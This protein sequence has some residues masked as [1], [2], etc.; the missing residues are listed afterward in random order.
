MEP[1]G[2]LTKDGYMGRVSEL[3]WILFSTEQEYLDYIKED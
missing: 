3:C 1:Y 2:Y